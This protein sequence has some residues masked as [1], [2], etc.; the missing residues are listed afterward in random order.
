M[1]PAQVSLNGID[2]RFGEPQALRNVS[3]EVRGGEFLTLLG[4][5]G[6]GKSTLLRIVAG[7]EVPSAGS[8]AIAGRPVDTV[9][10][11][12]RG[13]AMVFQNYALYP[14]LTAGQNI[15][16]PLV[17][18]RLNWWQRLPVLGRAMPGTRG[19]RAEIA[20]DVAR[21]AASLNIRHLLHRRP[22]QL[23]GGQRQRVALGRAMVRHPVLF[24]MDE[25]LANLD[26][27]L[28][29]HM[30]AELATLH[31]RLGVTF[32]YVTHDQV[33]AMT[34]SDRIAVM[35]DGEIRQ[36][37]TP[38]TVFRAP[39]DLDV[40]GFMTH[41]HL[42]RWPAVG[43]DDGTVAVAGTPVPVIADVPAGAGVTLAF[44]PE[45]GR[46]STKSVGGFVPA[47]VSHIELLGS[48]AL[49]HARRETAD[50]A[51]GSDRAVVRVAAD[52]T[53][54]LAI[55]TPVWVAPDAGR[56]WCFGADGARLSDQQ[57]RAA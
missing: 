23:S 46:L 17:M 28:R 39:V 37:G 44:R 55:G 1:Q 27:G 51:D 40:A 13:V 41:P 31:R 54:G 6:C 48:D 15:A 33:E 10:P 47:T 53:H 34:M 2:K 32:I 38:E 52:L 22:S 30:R 49:I 43:R 18:R 35:F 36:I 25:P 42:N 29:A 12:D 16:A 20:D 8:I 5:S 57:R 56:A 14:H 26:S 4:P 19:L 45:D 50:T 9:S 21:V 11:R 3:L 24:L 7:L